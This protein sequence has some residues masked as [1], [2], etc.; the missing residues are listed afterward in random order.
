MS[1][2]KKQILLDLFV[3]PSTVVP[4]L[5]GGTLLMLSSILGGSS[6]F[7]GFVGILLSIGA[8][9]TNVVFN[10]KKISHK[11][12]SRMHRMEKKKRDA[13]LNEL[14]AKLVR[15]K[16]PR[17]QTALRN[18]RTL[19]NSFCED[20]QQKKIT[21]SVPPNMLQLIED[22]FAECVH[23]L[24]RSYDIWKTAKSLQSDLQNSLLEQREQLIKDV[25]VSVQTLAET[26]SEVRVLK[27]K[28][29]SNEMQRLR[30]KLIS[31]LSVA[32]ATEESVM[33]LDAD[34]SRQY[35]EYE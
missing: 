22:I 19:Y 18:L 20:L 34:L 35:D 15:N 28:N 30:E 29:N 3:T 23:N 31:Q 8:L 27:L 12:V 26:I 10:L 25:E 9:L 7:F 2:L 32:K 1:E 16:D 5:I 17:D 14:D 21:N 11:A 6:A 33:S 24:S 4:F 13:E